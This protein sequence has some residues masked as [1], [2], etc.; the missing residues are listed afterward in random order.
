MKPATKKTK[1]QAAVKAQANAARALADRVHAFA[2]PA[3]KEIESAQAIARYLEEN[4]FETAF[5][6]K[7]IP[8]AFRAQWGSGKPV[9]GILGE[10]DA[11]PDCGAE[12]GTWG[13]GCGHDL[14]G[15]GSAAGAVA[16]K[17]VLDEAGLD[18]TVVYY[19]CP[20]EETLAGKVYMARDGG[21]RD[22]DFC[23]GWHPGGKAA[24]NN[25]GGSA[26]DSVVYEFS[27]RTAH[28]AWA[29]GGRSA[30]DAAVL[31]DVAANYLREHVEENVRI[32][33]VIRDGGDAPN[34]VPAY[35]K[36]WYY[37]R[38]KDRKQ[39]D[40]VR[41]RLD[42]CA[43]GAATATE[44]EMKW[45]RLTAVY[46]RLPNDAFAK[47]VLVN[48]KLFGAPRST[49][50][51]RR[52]VEAL[53][54][55]DVAF[56]KGVSD[57]FGTQGRGSTDEDNVSWLVPFGRFVMPTTAKDTAG[58]HRDKTA[59]GTLP[60][61]RRG[62]LQAAKVFAGCAVDLCTDA[63]LRRSIR[64]EFKKRTRGF[65]YDPLIPKRQPVPIDPP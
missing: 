8:T 21:F 55:K 24:A 32:H 57:G 54:K 56:P 51:D 28:G 22:L 59:Q 47:N 6:F 17:A 38:G 39:V 35:A 61:A 29:H 64:A 44:T 62:M 52:R 43:E 60:F 25:V 18:G 48:I 49:T 4:G 20:A 3:F 26:L 16:A 46:S 13:H 27:G 45:T 12:E 15:V 31:M 65:T 11:L 50:A 41:K 33:M 63:D 58:H 30:L 37:I 53:G 7:H 2:E 19:G 36:S 5:S 23:L 1:V 9:I 40:A 34:V 10:Y 14:L 42:L